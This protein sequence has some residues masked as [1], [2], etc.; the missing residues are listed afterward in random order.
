M[1]YFTK[2][3]TKSKLEKEYNITSSHRFRSKNDVQMAFA[4]FH[5]LNEWNENIVSQ[6]TVENGENYG[7]YIVLKP[8]NL[9]QRLENYLKP[10][11]FLPYS[12][13]SKYLWICVNDNLDSDHPDFSKATNLGKILQRV[14]KISYS[15]TSSTNIENIC[16]PQSKV[17]SIDKY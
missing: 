17:N 12:Y 10:K 13:E 5:Y 6:N 11:F 16:L 2:N 8:E 7:V 15:K 4:Y 9:R 3:L 1:F 14:R